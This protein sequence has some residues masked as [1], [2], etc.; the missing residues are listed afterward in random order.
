METPDDT[1]LKLAH[2][3]ITADLIDAPT[4][5]TERTTSYLRLLRVRKSQ[6]WIENVTL[7]GVDDTLVEGID[8]LGSSSTPARIF[9]RGTARGNTAPLLPPSHQNLSLPSSLSFRECV[10]VQRSALYIRIKA[11]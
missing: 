9:A 5:R 10:G 4:Q 1:D 2:L 3:Y 6:V 11:N 8:A 7:E